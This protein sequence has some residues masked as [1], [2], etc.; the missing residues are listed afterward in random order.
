MATLW[1]WLAV[2]G[3]GA[4][5]GLSPA[6]GW[7]FAAA[8]GVRAHDESQARRML[9][10]IGIG[11][12]ASV[13]IVACAFA[14]GMSLDRTRVQYLAGALLVGVA[15]YRLLRGAGQCTPNQHAGRPRRHRALVIPDG[16]CARGR[17]D[18]GTG[19][20]A[21]VPG[22]QSG[23]RDHRVGLA[24]PG[25]GCSRRPHG[26]DAG[27]DRRHRHRRV[28]RRRLASSFVERRGAA[29]GLD[30]GAGRHRRAVDGASL[31]EAA[32]AF[33]RE[34]MRRATEGRGR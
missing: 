19:A 26:C 11:H 21:T 24:V 8:C 15:A 31:N 30:G 25:T 14:Q 7:M 28:P 20:R 5:H 12:V 27:H 29:P 13:A 32:P 4:F 22:R 9:L 34:K 33:I 16:H 23:A 17:A 10:P 6:N 3:L 1:P 2:A 18:A